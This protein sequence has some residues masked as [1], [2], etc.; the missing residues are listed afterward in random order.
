M[1]ISGT[2]RH[3]CDKI[4][5]EY[6]HYATLNLG[7]IL[8]RFNSAIQARKLIVMNE[9]GMSNNFAGYM[10]TSNHDALLKVDIGD[11][12]VVCFEVSACCR[13]DISYFDW[14]GEILDHPDAPG[15]VISYLLSRN[16]TNWRPRKIPAT[17]MKKDIMRN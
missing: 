3:T 16:L 17:K 11:S 13:D 5:C 9:T 6:L 1:S 7:K 15:V 2:G 12:R 8:G 10:I 4:L 14:L